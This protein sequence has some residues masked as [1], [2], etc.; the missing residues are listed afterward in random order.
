L[1]FFFDHTQQALLGLFTLHYVPNYFDI[2]PMYIVA[3]GLLP[4]LM[5]LARI[6][7]LLVPLASLALYLAMWRYQL[8]FPAELH[9]SRPWFFNPLGWQLLFYTGFALGMGWLKP[10]PLSPWLV[11]LCLA[12]VL[13]SVPLSHAPLYTEIAWLDAA[14]AELHIYLQ[15]TNFGLLRWLHFLALAYLAQAFLHTRLH[16]LRGRLAT[17]VLKVGQHALP[18]FLLGMVLSYLAGMALDAFGRDWNSAAMINLAGLLLLTGAAYALAWFKSQPWK[19]PAA[20]PST[21]SRTHEETS[22]NEN[23]LA[24]TRQYS[25]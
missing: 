24:A 17:P 3:L 6:H 8:E 1:Y 20:V 21:L 2:L 13:L 7:A 23:I 19:K 25:P 4:A 18:L 16:W 22:R 15:K 11:A 14:R 12:F 5:L 9:S 10:P